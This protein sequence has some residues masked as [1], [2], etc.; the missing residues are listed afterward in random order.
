MHAQRRLWM[1]LLAAMGLGVRLPQA[2][3]AG[4]TPGNRAGAVDFVTGPAQLADANGRRTLTNGTVVYGGQRIETGPDAEVHLVFDDGGFLAV[5]PQSQVSIDQV[6]MAG[7]FDDILAMTLVR[8][9]LRS[10]TGWVGKF[11]RNN[12]QLRAGTATVGIRGTDHEVLYIPENDVRPGEVAGIHNWVHEGGTTLRN[13]GGAIDIGPGHAAWAAHDGR[14]PRMHEGLPAYLQRAHPRHEDRV[15]RHAS[16]IREHIER[17]MRQKGF[18]ARQEH[19][20]DAQRRHQQLQ[21]K[22]HPHPGAA[23]HRE[24]VQEARQ[25]WRERQEKHAPE[26]PAWHQKH[27]EHGRHN[28]R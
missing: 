3:A 23:P 17:R 10:V 18:L 2:R 11:D 15:N 21:E 13:A 9:A 26:E 22:S 7:A 20:E 25:R 1:G 4:P 6:K 24:K 16:A 19:L 5:R 27:G 12:Y 8:G 14:A 28:E